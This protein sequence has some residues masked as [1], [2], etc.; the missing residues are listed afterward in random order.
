VR[1]IQHAENFQPK[2]ERNETWS[3]RL[4]LSS[5]SCSCRK[6]EKT[7]SIF[8]FKKQSEIEQTS[9]RKLP[10]QQT[11]FAGSKSTAPISWKWPAGGI[12]AQ[13]GQWIPLHGVMLTLITDHVDIYKVEISAKLGYLEFSRNPDLNNQ[14]FDDDKY[15]QV[16]KLNEAEDHHSGFRFITLKSKNLMLLNQQLSFLIYRFPDSDKLNILSREDMISLT[17]NDDDQNQSV[18]IPVTVEPPKVPLLPLKSAGTN[19]IEKLISLVF[20]S[21]HASTSKTFRD[22]L[23]AD[24][25]KSRYKK[26]PTIVVDA[27]C[28]QQVWDQQGIQNLYLYCS[29][30]HPHKLAISQVDTEFL[31]YADLRYFSDIM[32]SDILELGLNYLIEF[33]VDIISAG[34]SS[35]GNLEKR[36]K[37][38]KCFTK[39]NLRTEFTKLNHNCFRSQ[40][41]DDRVFIGNNEQI[42]KTIANTNSQHGVEF[43]TTAKDLGQRI[44]VCPEFE[45]FI[46]DD[47]SRSKHMYQDFVEKDHIYCIET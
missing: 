1:K 39:F 14:H 13:P 46:S 41:G 15:F 11:T 36:S 21:H 24:F 26:V 27:T 42:R 2:I 4:S 31:L 17:F 30:S 7:I 3:H 22:D 6:D 28:D 18:V 34:S 47:V 20:V 38:G 10:L 23:M 35:T 32:N 5:T 33:G 44:A 43:W 12:H 45:K 9:Y 40:L 19:D 16:K 29:K 37:Y 25:E 8:D